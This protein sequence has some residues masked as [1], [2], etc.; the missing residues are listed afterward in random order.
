MPD[1]AAAPLSSRA[2][3]PPPVHDGVPWLPSGAM[4]G[5]KVLEQRRRF[6][7]MLTAALL[8]IGPP[9]LILGIRLIL[10]AASPSSYGPAGSPSTFAALAEDAMTPF[11]FIAAAVLG[12]AAGTTDLSDGVFRSLVL[13]G[14]SRVALYLARIPAGLA[15]IL[16]LVAIGYFVLAL[17][18]SFASGSPAPT[19][20]PGVGLPNVSE[21]V[22]TGLWVELYAV[23]GFVVGLGFSSLVGQRT[24]STISLV[25]FQIIVTPIAINVQIPHFVNLQRLVVGVP[26]RQLWPAA[27]SVAA[28]G[29]HGPFAPHTLPPMPTWAAVAVIVGWLVV[30]T[31]LGIR[32]MATRDA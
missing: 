32:K 5:A 20:P 16:P 14:R 7:L 24:V 29:R 1:V 31:T 10:H 4:I 9:V 21:L 18:T 3:P 30:W 8:T 19:G 25:A 26:L 17:V 28:G 6:G 27:V 11:C 2:T 15:L 12:A 23:V 22:D 13:T